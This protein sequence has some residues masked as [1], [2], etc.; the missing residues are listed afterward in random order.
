MAHVIENLL[1]ILTS[2]KFRRPFLSS[3]LYCQQKLKIS[4]NMLNILHVIM[5][6]KIKCSEI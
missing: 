2:Q 1:E 6:K 3:F 5:K 4:M